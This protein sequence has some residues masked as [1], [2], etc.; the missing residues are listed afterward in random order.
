MTEIRINEPTETQFQ[1]V[2]N[3]IPN[4]LYNKDINDFIIFN[5]NELNPIDTREH[6]DT[7]YDFIKYGSN[8]LLPNELIK[9]MLECPT[10]KSIIDRKADFVLGQGI[11]FNNPQMFQWQLD[12][13]NGNGLDDLVHDLALD[14]FLFGGFCNQVIWNQDPHNLI[15]MD[16]IYQKFEQ[17]RK[18]FSEDIDGN[19]YDQDLKI[20]LDWKDRWKFIP[21][22]YDYYDKDITY[23]PTEPV[24]QYYY[25]NSKGRLWYPNPSYISG[26]KSIQTEIELINFVYNFVFQSFNPCGV[27]Y[28]PWTLSPEQKLEFMKTLQTNSKGTNNAGKILALFGNSDITQKI[29]FIPFNDNISKINITSLYDACSQQIIEA[30]MLPSRSV[31]GLPGETS[32]TG[33]AD[34]IK[35]SNYIF[36]QTIINKARRIIKRELDK[37]IINAGFNTLDWDIVPFNFDAVLSNKNSSII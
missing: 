35:I 14:Y 18:G 26:I 9:L 30:H 36:E 23:P 22:S 3:N 1:Q 34:T 5:V 7:T 11:K 19:A 25:D 4:D 20:S 12:I 29:E 31:I 8:N 21:Q 33:D 2:L 28:I 24:F 15:V 10:H 32:L 6:L 16:I 27:L 17:V 37:I 13:N